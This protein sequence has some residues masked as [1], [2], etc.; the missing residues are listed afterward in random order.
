MASRHVHAARALPRVKRT[1][2]VGYHAQ[3]APR[4]ALPLGYE[5]GQARARAT[6]PAG[7]SSHAS[8][9]PARSGITSRR[10]STVPSA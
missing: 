2:V 5:T 1:D 6:H 8:A 9:E 3:P 10:S 7:R 4:D